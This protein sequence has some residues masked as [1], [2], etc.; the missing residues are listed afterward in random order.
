MT[1]NPF[2]IPPQ[3]QLRKD[4]DMERRAANDVN[5]PENKSSLREDQGLKSGGSIDLSQVE[6]PQEI[7]NIEWGEDFSGT[8]AL[9]HLRS[10]K[11]LKFPK[12]FEG[13][14]ILR[15]LE[16]A[17]GL[18]FPNDFK[19][20]LDFG[21]LASIDH[22]TLPERF[23]GDIYLRNVASLKGLYIP[24]G[25]DGTIFIG[26]SVPSEDLNT[27]EIATQGRVVFVY[28]SGAEAAR[29]QEVLP[30]ASMS[31]ALSKISGA[32]RKNLPR[33]IMEAFKSKKK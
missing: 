1:S 8:I 13:K 4:I 29:K 20:T 17:E 19:G 31:E 9:N 26:A 27:S 11:G 30:Q 25:F 12:H 7:K 2:E 3:P 24:P 21:D 18:V 28:P 5:V 10:A 22:L 15:S 14:L 6:D 32:L 33:A 16:S 23:K